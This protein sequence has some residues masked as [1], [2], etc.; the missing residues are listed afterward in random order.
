MATIGALQQI[1]VCIPNESGVGTS[2][3]PCT[4]VAGVPQHPVVTQAYVIDPGSQTYLDAVAAPFDYAV[5]GSI[6]MMVFTFVVGLYLAS[7]QV[8]LL[9]NLIR[10]R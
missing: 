6:W 3:S 1:V 5:A 7:S 4:D 9:L 8:G 10:G 2:V